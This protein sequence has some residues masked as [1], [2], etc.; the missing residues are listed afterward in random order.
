MQVGEGD[1]IGFV[2]GRD[3]EDGVTDLLDVNG[4]R[5]GC[6]LRVVALQLYA[7]GGIGDVVCCDWGMVAMLLNRV[8]FYTCTVLGHL[9]LEEG[10]IPNLFTNQPRLPL[11]INP[12]PQKQLPEKWIQRFLL[13]PKLLTA[14]SILLF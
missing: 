1:E 10:I 12:L 3:G 8:S 5:E 11:P 4:A 6:F 9:K 2:V 13:I 7:V 14:T